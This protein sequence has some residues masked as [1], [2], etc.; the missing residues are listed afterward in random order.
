[1]HPE[2]EY[3]LIKTEKGYLM[4]AAELAD[5]CLERYQLEGTVVG[6]CKGAALDM[7][8]LQ[9]PFQA[10]IVPVICGDHVTLEAGT[11]LV[12]TAPA[13]GLDDYFIGQK[14]GLPTDNPVGDDGKFLATVPAIG[15]VPL[16]GVFVW[17][18][19][20]IVLQAMEA[21]GHLLCLAQ[22]RHSYPH[23]WRHKTP[24]IF[25]ATTQWFIGMT[26]TSHPSPASGAGGWGAGN[27]SA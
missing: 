2:L 5:G 22:V 8:P 21:S 16:A 24:I 1:M 9:H 10:R 15:D 20:D 6:H 11:G 19:N 7:L 25:R 13:H 23:C 4:L 12:H 18:A 26:Q 17:K 14:Y 3:R 27:D